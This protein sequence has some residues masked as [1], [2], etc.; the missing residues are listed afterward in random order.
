M[1]ITLRQLRYFKAVVECGG[2]TRAAELL[3]VSQPTISAAVRDLEREVGFPLLEP[4]SRR[5]RVTAA[6]QIVLTAA[7]RVLDELDDMGE[8]LAELTGGCSGQLSI[9]ASSTPGTYLLPGLLGAFGAA[10]P[11]VQL[12]LEVSDTAAVL[13]RVAQGTLD[14]GVVGE[15]LFGTRVEAT[16]LLRDELVLILAPAHPLAI[17]AHVR[18]QD[19]S[20]EP[21]ILREPGSS[22]RAILEQAMARRAFTPRVAMELGNTEALKRSVAAGL[23]LGIV[24]SLAC[25]QEQEARQ[26][27]TRA[28]EDLQLTRGIYVV[29]RAGYRAT[30]LYERFLAALFAGVG[31]RG[32]AA[33]PVPPGSLKEGS[34]VS[35]ASS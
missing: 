21:L 34:C 30:A 33:E 20:E 23:G 17:A 32:G 25:E 18:L 5:A 35:P 27:V 12:R 11:Q 14:L 13:E 4:V 3:F 8:R 9:G 31:G 2:H 6:G 7:D 15:A 22:T 1:D 26:L 19:L 28:I 10:H 29:R 16:L 24:S